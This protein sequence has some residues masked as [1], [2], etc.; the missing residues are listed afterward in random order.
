MATITVI[1]PN[2]VTIGATLM[3]RTLKISGSKYSVVQLGPVE[4]FDSSE[5]VEETIQALAQK[6]D[7][8]D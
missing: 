2:R 4:E 6:I 7:E 8:Q 3:R 1:K 5:L